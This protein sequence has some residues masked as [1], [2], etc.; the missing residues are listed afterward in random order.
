[1]KH[2]GKLAVALGAIL[3]LVL[4]AAWLGRDD[5]GVSRRD[6]TRRSM[7]IATT[8]SPRVHLFGD[9]VVAEVRLMFDRR[10][11]RPDD[12]RV[13][14]LFE[15]YEAGTPKRS[16]QDSGRLTEVRYRF[17][18]T[19]LTR[20]C[21]PR[22][23]RR[24]RQFPPVRVFY[25]LRDIRARTN[26]IAEW[27]SIAA[28][29]RLGV[30]DVQQARWRADLRRLPPPSYAVSPGALAAVLFGLALALLLLAAALTRRAIVSS[31]RAGAELAAAPAAA[32][33]AQAVA[34][35]R[36]ACADGF[37]SRARLALE[38]LARELEHAG[39]ARPSS[40]ARRLA[41]SPERPSRA[42]VE[43]LAEDVEHLPGSGA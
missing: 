7:E 25:S 22:G 32:P 33:I 31:T 19:C 9:P 38:R 43:R 28:T 30:S 6:L 27:P 37:T 5:D 13:D 17:L 14:A 15:P 23:A 29:S 41:W 1:M 40:D 36:E 20:A 35:V 42:D 16:R 3:V 4:V 21:A 12:I 24:E 39:H 11:V 34:L 18:L 26:D 2:V 8:I 10:R